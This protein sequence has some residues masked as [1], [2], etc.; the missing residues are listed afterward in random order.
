MDSPRVCH[1]RGQLLY[2]VLYLPLLRLQSVHARTIHIAQTIQV[3]EST[4]LQLVSYCRG[5]E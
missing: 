1:S 2:M 5:K 4:R 3:E